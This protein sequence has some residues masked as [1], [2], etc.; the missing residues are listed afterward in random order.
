MGDLEL[1]EGGVAKTT[2]TAVTWAG[3]FLLD[4]WKPKQLQQTLSNLFHHSLSFLR[5]W[6][7][8]P[9]CCEQCRN[10]NICSFFRDA[11]YLCMNCSSVVPLELRTKILWIFLM[12]SALFLTHTSSRWL[13]ESNETLSVNSSPSLLLFLRLLLLLL[14][15]F[16]EYPLVSFQQPMLGGPVGC[17]WHNGFKKHH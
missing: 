6:G 2:G 10:T 3:D 1:G 11:F 5:S 13:A 17:V 12:L 7:N 14:L 15:L 16:P 8:L 4:G 9:W